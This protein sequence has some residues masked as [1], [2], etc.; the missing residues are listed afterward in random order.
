MMPRLLL[1][2]RMSELT[3]DRQLINCHDY[4]PKETVSYLLGCQHGH[5]VSTG[6]MA[7]LL[8]G[9]NF[10]KLIHALDGAVVEKCN[11]WCSIIHCCGQRL[12]PTTGLPL[13]GDSA[14]DQRA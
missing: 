9:S 14:S 10:D 7:V 8:S 4:A 3:E 6:H 11:D 1:V 13:A 5:D 12:P 2:V